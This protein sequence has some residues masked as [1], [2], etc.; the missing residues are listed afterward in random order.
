[1]EK[2]KSRCIIVIRKLWG[3]GEPGSSRRCSG[4]C[5]TLLSSPAPKLCPCSPPARIS[6]SLAAIR[7]FPES[8]G[9][10]QVIWGSDLQNHNPPEHAGHGSVPAGGWS[11]EWSSSRDGVSPLLQGL[12]GA[13]P[14]ATEHSWAPGSLSGEGRS[15]LSGLKSQPCGLEGD[16]LGCSCRSIPAPRASPAPSLEALVVQPV[17]TH[18]RMSIHPGAALS[19]PLSS[20][21]CSIG[22]GRAGLAPGAVTAT[23]PVQ[24]VLPG[25]CRSKLKPEKGVPC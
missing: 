25:Y 16:V 15:T 14:S 2:K 19:T 5:L 1:M 8:L 24:V 17:Q 22:G 10:S 7:S 20:C 9:V 12:F 21:P 18:R 3:P 4:S 23:V 11:E 6:C 13:E